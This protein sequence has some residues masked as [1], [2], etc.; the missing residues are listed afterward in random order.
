M[1]DWNFITNNLQNL[2]YRCTRW[3][4]KS[5]R[6]TLYRCTCWTT[7]SYPDTLVL[8]RQVSLWASFKCDYLSIT[9]TCPLKYVTIYFWGIKFKPVV[10]YSGLIS[11]FCW[12]LTRQS[13]VLFILQAGIT[14]TETVVLTIVRVSWNILVVLNKPTAMFIFWYAN[15]VFD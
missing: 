8:L 13:P 11:S 5:Y 14:D 9:Q 7:K 10:F 4:I 3:S 12:C 2:L 6:D 15:L 1:L